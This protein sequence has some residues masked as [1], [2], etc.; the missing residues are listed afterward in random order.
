ATLE[1]G[2]GLPTSSIEATA[3]AATCPS[4]SPLAVILEAV[5][6][7]FSPHGLALGPGGSPGVKSGDVHA[8]LPASPA[9]GVAV[10]VVAPPSPPASQLAAAV[11]PAS[12]EVPAGGPSAPQYTR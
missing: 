4:T 3:I 2:P 10:P 1:S 12:A 6:E 8:L 9:R 5:V 11:L 7:A